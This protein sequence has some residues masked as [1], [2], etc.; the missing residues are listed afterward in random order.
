MPKSTLSHFDEQLVGI[1]QVNGR[2]SFSELAK[3]LSVSR[4]AVARRVSELVRTG[5]IRLVAAVHPR[6]LGLNAI[7]HISIRLNGSASKVI[8]ALEELDAAA[9]V[10]LTTGD[11]GVMAEL[12]YPTMSDLY[13][14]V[15]ALSALPQVGSIKVLIYQDVLRSFFLGEVPDLPDFTLDELDL[16]LIKELQHDGR[17]GFGE[18]GRRIGLSGS[19]ARSRV[20]RLLE[21]RVLQ[22]GA[23][24]GR[25]A[26]AKGATLG[27]GI[28]TVGNAPEVIEAINSLPGIEFIARCFGDYD[29]VVTFEAADLYA[30]TPV[31][32]AVRQLD[33]VKSV[34]VWAHLRIVK[35]HYDMS[36][37]HL[38]AHY[39]QPARGRIDV[40]NVPADLPD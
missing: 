23:I 38:P 10:S 17:L 25:D 4:A 6:I 11:H 26:A 24:R 27:M 32:D 39:R 20:L 7:A 5:A 16:L 19:A 34:S 12:R 18:L 3:R 40:A 22:I 37:D 31:I 29:L 14:S 1:L 2:T 35:E 28:T 9:F 8:E 30:A 15:D 21:T 13:R 36:L 33:R